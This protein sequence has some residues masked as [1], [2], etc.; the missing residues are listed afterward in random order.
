MRG[1]RIWLASLAGVIGMMTQHADGVEARVRSADGVPR[2]EID[3]KPVRSRIFF[4]NPRHGVLRIG[5]EPKQYS[6]DFT[7]I[8]DSQG[9]GTFHFRFGQ[10]PGRCWIDDFQV[11]ELG[12]ER[13]VIGPCTF[14]D[15]KADFTK[16]WSFWPTGEENTVGAVDVVPVGEGKALQVT[17]VGP[18]RGKW[19]DFHVYTQPKLEIKAGK[20]YRVSFRAWADRYRQWT[21]GCYR[22]GTPFLSLMHTPGVFEDQIRL[23]AEVGVNMVSFSLPMPWPKPGEEPDWTAVE[24]RCRVVL[25]ANPKALLLPRIGMEPPGWW[26]EAHPGD[27]MRWEDGV[28]RRGVS[29]SSKA[30]RRDAAEHL[31]AVVAF[32][33]A[34]FPD[35]MIGY[36]P[37]G[38][39]TGEWFYQDTWKRQFPGY[40]PATVAAWREWLTKT[41]GTDAALQAAW[42]QADATLATAAVPSPERRRAAPAGVLRDPASEQD[43]IDFAIFRQ[44]AMADCVCALA[45]AIR[46]ASHGRKLSVFFYG[47]V[48]EFAAAY[49]GPSASGHYALRRLLESPDIDILCSPISYFDRGLGESAPSMTATES[50]TQAGKLWLNEDDTATYLC[51]GVFPGHQEKVDTLEKTNQELLRNVGQDACRNLATWWMDLGATGWFNDPGMWAEMKRLEPMDMALLDPPHPYRPEVALVNHAR[52]MCQVATGGQLVTRPLVYESRAPA[53]RMGAPFGQYLLDDV[54]AGRVDAKLFVIL[55]AWVLTAAEREELRKQLQGKTVIWCYAPG[56]Y[57]GSAPSPAAMRQLT[58]FSLS[59]IANPAV[60][61]ANATD[62]G[63][64]AGL[65]KEMDGGQKPV[66]PLFAA[67]RVPDKQVLARYPSGGAAVAWTQDNGGTSIFCGIPR[68]TVELLRF[69]A[70]R[71][72]VHLYTEDGCVLYANGPYIVLHGTAP[73]NVRL[74]LGKPKT[75]VDILEKRGFSRARRVTIRLGFGKTRILKILP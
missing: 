54:L 74:D 19:P 37:A 31:R 15:G 69:A 1:A 49:R 38:H 51:S 40:A 66:R 61:K 28:R 6:F 58:G 12:T 10:K 73:D 60:P 67:E 50:V 8:A 35:N 48:F 46:E 70:K 25:D 36:H 17:L 5:R 9:R 3:G 27:V 64:A 16:Q 2:I 75:L 41:Y 43:I 71:A 14:A 32:L 21:L 65:G 63:I 39:N 62:S 47:Y 18:K 34:K 20:R 13:S 11:L 33:E 59:P 24:A 42:H 57:D 23:A 55:N 53:A 45:K 30:Y 29:P 52:S 7:A 56:Y 44:Q 72:G 4:G 26:K 22:P 68:L